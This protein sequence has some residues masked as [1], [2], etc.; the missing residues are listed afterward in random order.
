LERFQSTQAEPLAAPVTV[1]R[2]LAFALR[3]PP[4][5]VV[6]RPGR[7]SRCAWR[8]RQAKA[9]LFARE[10]FSDSKRSQ[11][12]NASRKPCGAGPAFNPVA[13][14]CATSAGSFDAAAAPLRMT[15][16]SSG[17]SP[18]ACFANPAYNFVPP[19][20]INERVARLYGMQNVIRLGLI[21][22]RA[23]FHE[24]MA[25]AP[26]VETVDRDYVSLI[27]LQRASIWKCH[28]DD[29]AVGPVAFHFQF[30]AEQTSWLMAGIHFFHDAL[31]FIRR[32]R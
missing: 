11:S 14:R 23:Q 20:I 24:T 7:K 28:R 21:K 12:C 19:E 8:N 1:T 26:G 10:L 5:R 13:K 31:Y 2:V 17:D 25:A 29:P 4:H 27:A 15:G 32:Q 9:V 16:P 22:Q 18:R 3:Q 30:D 6:N